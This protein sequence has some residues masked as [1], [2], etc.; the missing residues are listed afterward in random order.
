LEAAGFGSP[1]LCYLKAIIRII[2]IGMSWLF[3][4][5]KRL[6]QLTG[7]TA[8]WVALLWFGIRPNINNFSILSLVGLH[9]L[10]PLGVWSSWLMWRRWSQAR[11]QKVEEEKQAQAVAEQQALQ[12][13]QRKAFEESMRHRQYAIDCR[14]AT[15]CSD[16][17]NLIGAEEVM[18]LDVEDVTTTTTERLAASLQMQIADLA[19]NLPGIL[20]LPVFVVESEVFDRAHAAQA[21]AAA[22]PDQVQPAVRIL[23]TTDGVVASIFARFESDPSMPGAL[24]IAVDGFDKLDE[25]DSDEF[26][27]NDPKPTDALVLMLCT[28]PH[29]D[30]ALQEISNQA[31]VGSEQY[32]PMTPFWERNRDQLK[33]LSERLVKLQRDTLDAISTLPVLG[34]LRRPAEVA[35]KKAETAWARAIE[36]ALINASLLPLAF[37]EDKPDAKPDESEERDTVACGWIVH[38]AGSF[39]TA[40]EKLSALGRGLDDHGIRLNIIREATNVLAQAK[41][42]TADQWASVALALLRA[43]ALES[44]TLWAVFGSRPS[45]GLVTLKA[46]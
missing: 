3:N 25:E 40:G 42:G 9:A 44:P 35:G 2:R 14:W 12:E 16:Q 37:Q 30:A 41:L 32:D 43:Q 6:L 17:P 34:Q 23:P 13:A 7:L 11:K 5:F 21:I 18:P 38:N 36:H 8:A 10:P 24:F 22:C 29:F 4:L 33:G 15:V 19:V 45:V 39:E 31:S 27:Y 46:A 26:S 20:R 1:L 28:H